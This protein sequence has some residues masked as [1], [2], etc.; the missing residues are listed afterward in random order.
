[1]WLIAIDIDNFKRVN[2]TYG[3]L[4]GNQV[5]QA[6]ADIFKSSVRSGDRVCRMGGDEFLIL[7]YGIRDSKKLS[8]LL[9]RIQNGIERIS[10]YEDCRIS[11]SI[12]ATQVKKEEMFVSALERA[13]TAL[14]E[15]KK[16]GKNQWKINEPA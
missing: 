4:A 16:N 11:I 2:D 1:M 14:Y 9:D 15:A 5:L 7:C 12:G 8:L 10:L 13:D 3:H 6:A